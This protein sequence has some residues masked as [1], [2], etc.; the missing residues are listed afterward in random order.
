MSSLE[1]KLKGKEQEAI[2]WL[3]AQDIPDT[4]ELVVVKDEFKEDAQHKECLYITYR[5]KE[6]I[7]VRQ[8]YTA[9]TYSTLRK[10]FEKAGGYQSLTKDYHLYEKRKVGRAF[11]DRL[12]P[13]AN[14]EPS[15]K[16]S[17]DL[18]E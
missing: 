11:H 1:E 16:K 13:V 18:Q 17:K 3:N 12:Y 8:K 5:T 2:Q 10:A 7:N 4:I 14:P 15:K 9:S 6:N